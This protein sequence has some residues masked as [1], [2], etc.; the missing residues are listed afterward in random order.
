MIAEDDTL[1]DVRFEGVM[2]SKHGEQVHLPCYQSNRIIKS[3][4]SKLGYNRSLSKI[5]NSRKGIDVK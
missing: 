3:N 4:Q 2:I 1:D 5:Y